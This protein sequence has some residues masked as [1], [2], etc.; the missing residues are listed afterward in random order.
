[1]QLS[2]AT[3]RET[4]LTAMVVVLLFETTPKLSPTLKERV[5]KPNSLHKTELLL[6]VMSV[7][8]VV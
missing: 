2:L 8:A 6:T 7:V 1:M 4:I 3:D 5:Y